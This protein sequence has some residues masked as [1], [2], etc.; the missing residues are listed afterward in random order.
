MI[1]NFVFFGLSALFLVVSGIFLVK[2]LE[3]IAKFLHVS[4]FVAA[5]LIMAIATSIPELFV[6]ISSAING[7]P[8]LSLGNIL[9]ANIID[10]TLLIGIFVILGKGI[11]VSAK[12]IEPGDYFM[13]FSVLLLIVL[14][15]LGNSL[16]RIDGIILLSL[17]LINTY[18]VIKKS[19]RYSVKFNGTKHTTK[20]KIIYSMLFVISL[21]ALFL[22]SKFIV[23]YSQLI[24]VDLHIPL[25]IVGLFLISFATTL[26]ELIFGVSAV[27]MKHKDMSIGDQVGTIF[28]NTACILG[29]VSIISP[30][31]IPLASFLIPALFLLV[32]I[33]IFIWFVKTKE[34]LSVIE[35]IILILIYVLF[36]FIQFFIK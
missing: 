34:K 25:I 3:K 31:T 13:F 19:S 32:S 30:I 26:P 29:I 11:K 9:G 36:V 16:S 23:K 35:G 4:E 28:F 18:R 12:K 20:E 27:L 6:G 24:A 5:F 21:I 14:Y 1:E 7:N 8:E 33:G 10:I 17:Y 15:F 2:S 22:S